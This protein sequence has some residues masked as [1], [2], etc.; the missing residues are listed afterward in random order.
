MLEPH[1]RQAA[2]ALLETTIRIAPP[3]TR[4]WGEGM[5]GELPHV[6]GPWAALTWAL[7]SASVL[8][9]R[10][11]VS[12]FIPGRRGQNLVPNGGLFARSFPLREMVLVI[13]GVFVVGALLFF[14]GPPFRHGVRISLEAWH[15]VLLVQDPNVPRNEAP[16]RT[17]P[18]GAQAFGRE[19]AARN[20]LVLHVATLALVIFSAMVVLAA[21]ALW[22]GVL[23]RS[24]RETPRPQSGA[25]AALLA[26]ALGFLLS[27]AT[28]YLTYRPYWYIHQNQV[29][30]GNRSRAEAAR[31]F[32]TVAQSL[33]YYGVSAANVSLYFWVG[34]TL[35]SVIGLVLILLRHFLGRPRANQSA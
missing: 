8:V 5:L 4:E 2:I 15:D 9:K 17:E 19:V 26:G 29:L 32:L 31:D 14:L 7:G 30:S 18:L 3:D 1:L 35:L 13:C 12:L 6:H 22:F 10:A 21:V 33:Q 11:L 20:A 24:R 16:G 23:K 27:S 25:W 34:V 28:I